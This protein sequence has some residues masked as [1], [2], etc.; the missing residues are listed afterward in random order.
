MV[1]TLTIL[2][3]WNF[4]F[5]DY[6]TQE[7]IVKCK[8]VNPMNIIMWLSKAQLEDDDT[9][10]L[11]PGEIVEECI[12]IVKSICIEGLEFIDKVPWAQRYRFIDVAIHAI[13]YG[14]PQP[15]KEEPKNV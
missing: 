11:P 6:I 14:M 9:K 8:G 12:Q 2:E 1:Q 4:T 13:M 10:R 5:K 7:D 15:V 3:K